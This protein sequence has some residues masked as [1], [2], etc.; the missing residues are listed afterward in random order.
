MYP[1]QLYL[2]HH[3][4][5]RSDPVSSFIQAHLRWWLSCENLLMG[6]TSP[7]PSLSVTLTSDASETGWG[8]HLDDQMFAGTWS[9][10]ERLHHLELLA[11]FKALQ[12]AP[13]LVEVC[14]VLVRT[15][16]STVSYL[17][18]HGGTHSPS[19]CL[20]TWKLHGCCLPLHISLQAIYL[21]GNKNV[22]ADALLRGRSAPQNGLSIAQ[23]YNKSSISWAPP[24]R[25][26]CISS[27]QSAASLLL[28]LSKTVATDALNIDWTNIGYAF[29][30]ISLL[31]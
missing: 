24:H 27:Q 5:P 4:R 28:R 13:N 2:L 19:L 16:N 29:P 1:L 17:N 21:V 14:Q 8:A 12:S 10:S 7:R 23:H 30:P 25:S 18:S 22:I 6:T 26:L 9:T 20:L 31:T 11:V 3:Y 15:D